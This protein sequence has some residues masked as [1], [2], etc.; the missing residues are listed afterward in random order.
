LTNPVVARTF[1]SLLADRTRRG[2]LLKA[3][4]QLDPA[5]ASDP[6]LGEAVGKATAAKV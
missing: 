5:A 6:A 1:G 4:L 2:D 3:L